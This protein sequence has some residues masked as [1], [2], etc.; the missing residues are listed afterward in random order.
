MD[1]LERQYR[2]WHFVQLLKQILKDPN[3]ATHKLQKQAFYKKIT[4]YY[5]S[6]ANPLADKKNKLMFPVATK[7]FKEAEQKGHNFDTMRKNLDFLKREFEDYF[8]ELIKREI[9]NS[10][11]DNPES[12]SLNRT[13]FMVY[14]EIVVLA[15]LRFLWKIIS[16]LKYDK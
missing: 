13:S 11:G 8:E 12:Y 1:Y 7:Q 5:F 9:V 16:F 4:E 3:L 2:L 15:S 10:D 6:K 14:W